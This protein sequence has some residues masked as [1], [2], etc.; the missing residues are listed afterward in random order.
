MRYESVDQL[1]KAL[2]EN[3]FH[4]AKDSK[5]AA[6]RALGTIVEII[7]FYLLKTW[8][9]HDCISIETRI[10]EYGNPDITHNVEYSLHPVLSKYEIEVPNE[11]SSITANRI[12]K[13]LE[14]NLN[15]QSFDKTNNNLLSKHR[16][17]RNACTVATSD[18]ANLVASIMKKSD[19][20]IMI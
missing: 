20:K 18:T 11:A 2:T 7:T 14:D 8:E 6:G 3:I 12:L 19:A 9:L 13:A 17:I 16:I 1:Q 5:K 4:Y 10:P 15:L